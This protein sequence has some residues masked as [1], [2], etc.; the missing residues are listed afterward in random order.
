MIYILVLITGYFCSVL[1]TFLHDPLVEWSK[2]AKGLVKTQASETGEIVNEKVIM[3]A[4]LFAC[5][6]SSFAHTPHTHT[7]V[8]TPTQP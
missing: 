5:V 7:L 1:K 6:G 3:E 4:C 2:P 8:D